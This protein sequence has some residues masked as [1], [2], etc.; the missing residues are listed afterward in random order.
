MSPARQLALLWAGVAVACAAGLLIAP[1]LAPELL[2]AIA[3]DLPACA[4]KSVAG[5]PCP[6]CGASRSTLALAGLDPVGALA[7]NPLVT[8]AWL[9]LIVGGIGAGGLALAG[10]PLPTLP[11][12]LP[13]ALRWSVVAAVAANW[14]YL[15]E[16]GV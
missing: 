8:L 10:R 16:R 3:A 13:L 5:L 1:R 11:R 2:P 12:R 7:T 15:L 4:V 14:L 6:T 9:A